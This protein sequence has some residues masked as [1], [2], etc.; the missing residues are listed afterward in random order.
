AERV[1]TSYFPP[2]SE[3]VD[4]IRPEIENPLTLNAL[5]GTLSG[6]G[7]A[8]PYLDNGGVTLPAPTAQGFDWCNPEPDPFA[9]SQLGISTQPTGAKACPLPG[10]AELGGQNGTRE[11]SPINHSYGRQLAL[12]WETGTAATLTAD[13]PAASSDM[14]GLKALA[15]GADVNFF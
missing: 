10:K 5:G 13:I 8:Y 15:M 2:A 7:F 3:R 1:S 12:A 6:T 9:P 11:N 4:L 14:S